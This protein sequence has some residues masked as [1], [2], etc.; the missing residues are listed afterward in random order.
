MRKNKYIKI[1]SCDF[2]EGR[3]VLRDS[4]DKIY[5]FNASEVS[6]L[7]GMSAEELSSAQIIAGGM[8]LRWKDF[9]L[10]LF[11]TA[12]VAPELLPSSRLL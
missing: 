5:E 9:D 7:A 6:G 10:D 8:G 3:F 1:I 4:T 2:E 11:V 12:I